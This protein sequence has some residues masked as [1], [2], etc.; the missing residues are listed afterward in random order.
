MSFSTSTCFLSSLSMLDRQFESLATEIENCFLELT[1]FS[2]QWNHCEAN[3]ADINKRLHL[4]VVSDVQGKG[5]F[6]GHSLSTSAY[7]HCLIWSIVL[8]FTCHEWMNEWIWL[9]L[10]FF[11]P[12]VFVQSIMLNRTVLAAN[13]FSQTA[14]QCSTLWWQ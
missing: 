4:S 7:K 3:K 8:W 1:V 13:S 11:L 12:S 6:R 14:A 9:Y 10:F 5:G 2:A